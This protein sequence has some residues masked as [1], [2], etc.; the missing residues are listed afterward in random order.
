LTEKPGLTTVGLISTLTDIGLEACEEFEDVFDAEEVMPIRSALK[1]G[2][3]TK[4]TMNNIVMAKTNVKTNAFIIYNSLFYDLFK[5]ILYRDE[6][7]V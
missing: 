1:Y 3:L 4:H 2:K 7:L 5:E 6:S